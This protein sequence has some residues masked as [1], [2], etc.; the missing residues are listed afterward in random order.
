MVVAELAFALD[1]GDNFGPTEL[2]RGVVGVT[3]LVT[4]QSEVYKVNWRPAHI[5]EIVKLCVNLVRWLRSRRCGTNE[6]GRRVRTVLV[7]SVSCYSTPCFFSALIAY[8]FDVQ[9]ASVGRTT[10]PCAKFWTP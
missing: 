5:I 8:P 7:R 1:Q 4:N 6:N 9:F 10:S 2:A 3:C